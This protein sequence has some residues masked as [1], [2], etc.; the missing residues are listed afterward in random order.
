VPPPT[1]SIHNQTRDI[2]FQR[3]KITFSEAQSF[4]ILQ[5]KLPIEGI[6]N[7]YSSPNLVM[8]IKLRII[9]WVEYMTHAEETKNDSN[10]IR[11]E[12]K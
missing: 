1:L 3:N 6:Y 10:D 11:I 5:R 2:G 7:F 8:V 9:R 4:T 12:K